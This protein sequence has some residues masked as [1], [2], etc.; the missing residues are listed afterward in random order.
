GQLERGRD[1]VQQ[2][3]RR[4]GG[5]VGLAAVTRKRYAVRPD[6]LAVLPPVERERPARQRL[7]GVPFALPVVEEAAGREARLQAADEAIGLVALGRP[8]GGRVPLGRF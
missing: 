3:L 8:D 5:R 1:A 6:R 4:G 2:P 7:A